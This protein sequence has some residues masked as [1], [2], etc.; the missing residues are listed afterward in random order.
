MLEVFSCVSLPSQA[1]RLQV[2]EAGPPIS[3]LPA[4]VDLTVEQV[5]GLTAELERYHSRFGS[6]FVRQ[7]QREW[8]SKYLQGLLLPVTPRKAIAP[9][10]IMFHSPHP[11]CPF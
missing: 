1:E 5:A 4:G 9:E 8:S 11:L 7:E 3:A 6:L 10:S 2:V